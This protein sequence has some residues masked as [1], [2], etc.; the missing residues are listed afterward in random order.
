MKIKPPFK[1][2]G[3]KFFLNSW[4]LKYFPKNYEDYTYVEP[5]CGSASILL[6]KVK[7]NSPQMEIVNDIDLGIIQIFKALRDEPKYFIKKLNSRTYSERVFN[8]GLKAEKFDDYIDHAVCEFVLRKMSRGGL[9]KS[10]EN[11]PHVWETAIDNLPEVANRIKGIYIFNKPAVQ[12]ISAF[13]SENTICYV[14]PPLVEENEKMTTDNHIDLSK[15][16]MQF[17]GKILLS[18]QPSVLYNRLY[19]DWKCVKK[20]NK[21]QKKRDCLWLNC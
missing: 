10:F 2:D 1:A 13:D 9:K 11:N 15:I 16:L 7:S 14:D 3:N 5:Y 20:R 6:N 21:G 18:G 19:Q 8:R 4:I 17:R 12:V